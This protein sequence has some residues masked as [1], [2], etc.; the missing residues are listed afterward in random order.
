MVKGWKYP[1]EVAKLVKDESAGLTRIAHHYVYCGALS[2]IVSFTTVPLPSPGVMGRLPPHMIYSRCRTERRDW[3]APP[4]QESA[5]CF[6][7]LTDA[8]AYIRM[9]GTRRRW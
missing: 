1:D 8:A 2:G 5:I 6:L 7:D 3:E 9:P 4:R